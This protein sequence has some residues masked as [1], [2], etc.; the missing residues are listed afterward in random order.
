M[1]SYHVYYK[2]K[3]IK[4]RRKLI[5]SILCLNVTNR[6]TRKQ[7]YLLK[8]F[9]YLQDYFGNTLLHT[10]VL[11]NNKKIIKY[12]LKNNADK[13]IKNKYGLCPKDLIN[14]IKILDLFNKY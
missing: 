9:N 2:K 13:N 1:N 7:K 14:N 8:N 6:V 11:H 12:L 5:Y 10:A 4:I 3:L